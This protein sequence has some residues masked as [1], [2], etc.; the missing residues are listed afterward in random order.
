MICAQGSN[1]TRGWGSVEHVVNMT[2]RQAQCDT[3]WLWVAFTEAETVGKRRINSFSSLSWSDHQTRGRG[4][5]KG[6]KK[7]R[8]EK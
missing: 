5:G 6:R 2:S 7:E 8:R 1:C 3:I 4:G